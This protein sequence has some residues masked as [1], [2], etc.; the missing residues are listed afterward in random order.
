VGP[1]LREIEGFAF[2]GNIP[3]IEA[4]KMDGPRQGIDMR[5]SIAGVVP[6][7]DVFADLHNPKGA[8]QPPHWD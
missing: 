5:P 3:T 8:R 4:M 1:P 6:S 7:A 2:R